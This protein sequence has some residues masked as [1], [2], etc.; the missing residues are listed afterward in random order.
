MLA[1]DLVFAERAVI[2]AIQA[3]A[4]VGWIVF[5]LVTFGQVIARYVFEIPFPW[6][7]ELARFTLI[8][9]SFLGSIELA[10]LDEHIDID[11]F[12]P[13][14]SLGTIFNAIKLLA[15][16]GTGFLLSYGTWKLLPVVSISRLPA[17]GL[18]LS[19]LYAAA[20]LAGVAFIAIAAIRLVALAIDSAR[21]RPLP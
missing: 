13:S 16:G 19:S 8:W 12:V 17:T 14:G 9:F 6:A 3:V 2:A 21:A 10:I 5:I 20:T 4:I 18:P 1:R 15:I 7:E 11:V